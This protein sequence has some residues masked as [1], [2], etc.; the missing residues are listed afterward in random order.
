MGLPGSQGSAS[1]VQSCI[2]PVLASR[3]QQFTLLQYYWV[4]QGQLLLCPQGDIPAFTSFLGFQHLQL[5]FGSQRSSGALYRLC[6]RGRGVRDQRA[7]SCSFQR[8]EKPKGVGVHCVGSNPV[9][10]RL[11]D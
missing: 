7:V 1:L 8:A 10:K 11:A 3:E 9:R 2:L 6:P 5:C 4:R